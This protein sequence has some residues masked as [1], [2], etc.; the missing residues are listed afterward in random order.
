MRSLKSRIDNFN[1]LRRKGLNKLEG[2]MKEHKEL[3]HLACKRPVDIK[4]MTSKIIKNR[5]N[6]D[7]YDESLLKCIDLMLGKELWLSESKNLML[8]LLR[9][10]K[11]SNPERAIEIGEKYLQILND[12]RIAKTI[13]QMHIK[14]SSNDK[15]IKSLESVTDSIWVNNKLIQIKKLD[16]GLDY[17]LQFEARFGPISSY[18]NF[19]PTI[20]IYADVDANVIDGS[21]IWLSSISEAFCHNDFNVHVLLKKNIERDV[22]LKPLIENK[23]IKIIEPKLFGIHEKQIDVNLA[24]ELIQFLDGYYGGYSRILLRGFELCRNASVMKSLNGRIW[25]YLT[26]YYEI[27]KDSRTIKEGVEEYF[28]EFIHSFD[29]F[30]V[31]TDSIK[32][33]FIEKFGVPENMISLLPPMIPSIEPDGLKKKSKI[34]NI[35]YAGKIAPLWGVLELIE[36]GRQLQ[37]AGYKIRIHVVGDKIHRNTPEFPEFLESTRELLNET[38]FIEW[39]GGKSRDETINIMKMMD[40]CW[41]Y[42]SKVLEQNTLELSTKLLE[43]MSIGNPIVLTNSVVHSKLLGEDY[44]YFVNDEKELFEVMTNLIEN[45][46]ES[47]DFSQKLIE[48]AESYT[49]ANAKANRISPLLKDV[50][51]H[52]SVNKKRI[53]INGHDLK[54]IAEFESYLKKLGH[55][56]RRDLW[57]WGDPINLDRSKSLAEWSDVIFSEWGLANSVWYSQNISKNTRHIIRIHLQEI[58][59]RARKFPP[60]IDLNHVSKIIFIAEHIRNAAIQMFDWPIEKTMT[61]P[62]FVD[63]DKFV[64]HKTHVAEKTLAIVGIVPQRKRL[65]RAIDLLLKLR[66]DDKSWK[67]IIKGNL[68]HDYKFMHAPGRKKEL[69]YYDNEYARIKD[70]GITDSVVFDGYTPSLPFWYKKVGYILSPSDFESFHYSIAEGVS[71]GAIPM[72]WEWDGSKDLYP[73]EW[74]FRDT[75]SIAKHIISNKDKFNDNENKNRKFVQENYGMK[76]ILNQMHLETIGED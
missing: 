68:P 59:K 43:L 24:M 1:R 16:S 9:S 61:I 22:V 17:N 64:M 27:S 69:E 6:K 42:R 23:N 13:V 45:F 54:F 74:S 40:I 37:N 7:E 76:K 62:N 5:K 72:I 11:N 38:S 35:G 66:E 41:A 53:T 65:D 21:S 67:L 4:H 51:R 52:F 63:V 56:V 50:R 73:S 60:E 30:L 33:E 47:R 58:N 48:K 28:H 29:R 8:S 3:I 31:Q 25:A 2:L 18:E 75:E 20:C 19:P 34:I 39:H 12:D 10:Y 49:I 55:E 14:I 57:N 71:S 36:V 44:P 15:I 26:D 46:D 32:H 70:H